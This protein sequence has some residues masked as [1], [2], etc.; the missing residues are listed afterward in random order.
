MQ[1]SNK[2]IVPV[3]LLSLACV[4]LVAVAIFI[5]VQGC[6]A[7]PPPKYEAGEVLQ[8]KLTGERVLVLRPTYNGLYICKTPQ[9]S[10]NINYLH[11]RVYIYEAELEPVSEN[12]P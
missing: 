6:E 7:Y 1:Q 11:K 10:S 12:K 4:L 2:W 3:T 9:P 8:L 5:G